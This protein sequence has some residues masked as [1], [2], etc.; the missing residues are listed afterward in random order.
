MFDVQSDQPMRVSGKVVVTDIKMPFGSMVAFM[1]KAA[2]ASIPAAIIVTFIVA[3]AWIFF[4]GLLA[5]GS[6]TAR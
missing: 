3:L 6:H 2:L 4:L 1:V 5:G